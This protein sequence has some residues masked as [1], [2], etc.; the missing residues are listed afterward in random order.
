M[1]CNKDMP[2][3]LKIY[4]IVHQ[5]GG[6]GKPAFLYAQEQ[7]KKALEAKKKKTTDV[8]DPEGAKPL[9]AKGHFKM[10]AG[11]SPNTFARLTNIPEE[12]DGDDISTV[13]GGSIKK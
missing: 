11:L 3:Q 8:L 12:Q 10:Q 2:D 9:R 5:M 13:N 4:V 1:C 6:F 7:A